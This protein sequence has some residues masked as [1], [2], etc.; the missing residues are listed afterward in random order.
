MY[1]SRLEFDRAALARRSLYEAHRALWDVFSDGPDRK[2]DF[3][4]REL[5]PGV[6]LTV[7]RREP[8]AAWNGL[9]RLDVK[10]YAPRLRAGERVLFSLRA[11][12][13]RKTRDEAGRQVRHDIVQDLRTR[14]MAGGA[15]KEDLPPRLDLAERAA[16]DWLAA[17]GESLGL[18]PEKG[19]VLVEAYENQ[20]FRKTRDG[21]EVV[22]SML[23]MRGFAAVADPEALRRALFEGVG[24]AKAYGCGLLLVRRA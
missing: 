12:P 21:R 11:N 14:L 24:P 7:S 22:V 4:Y 1:M 23:D 16:A 17:R 19:T 5:D 2:R 3:L 15:L 8:P 6:F 10:P 18:A 20:R 13:V 9:N